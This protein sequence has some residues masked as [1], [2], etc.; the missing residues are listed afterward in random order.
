MVQINIETKH[1]EIYHCSLSLYHPAG[2][3]STPLCHMPQLRGSTSCDSPTPATWSHNPV[4]AR[5]LSSPV[6]QPPIHFH[7]DSHPSQLIR[8]IISPSCK[9]S[10]SNVIQWSTSS[11]KQTH[12]LEKR[13]NYY[14]LHI[15]VLL[16]RKEVQQIFN[17]ENICC[18]VILLCVEEV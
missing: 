10:E 16:R 5:N 7:P 18:Y 14:Y 2:I 15:C 11:Y 9:K 12:L 6:S 17:F 8:N 1:V 3:N 13:H 4:A